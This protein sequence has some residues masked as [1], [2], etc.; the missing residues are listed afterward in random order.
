MHHSETTM[1]MCYGANARMRMSSHV[2]PAEP[3]THKC[4]IAKQPWLC[5]MTQMHKCTIANHHCIFASNLCEQMSPCHGEKMAL[6]GSRALAAFLM[7][8]SVCLSVCP[9]GNGTFSVIN[10]SLQRSSAVR[11]PLAHVGCSRRNLIE[12]AKSPGSRLDS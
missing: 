2:A 3:H 7:C 9:Y 10:R 4:T 6:E 11:K 12:T 8:L 1:A 5:A